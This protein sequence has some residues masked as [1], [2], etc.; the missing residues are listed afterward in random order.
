MKRTRRRYEIP[1]FVKEIKTIIHTL[2]SFLIGRMFVREPNW[3]LIGRTFLREPSWKYS[4]N[5]DE[6]IIKISNKHAYL[7][8]LCVSVLHGLGV[9]V[10]CNFVVVIET[11]WFWVCGMFG[12]Y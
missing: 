8:F 6:A 4:S 5:C 1:I 7:L 9:S 3:F 12:C 10:M 11:F 2:S